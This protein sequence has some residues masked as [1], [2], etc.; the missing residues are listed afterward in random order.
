MNQEM[1]YL[2]SSS[3]NGKD[4]NQNF[5]LSKIWRQIAGLRIISSIRDIFSTTFK[6]IAKDDFIIGKVPTGKNPFAVAVNPMT[7]RI[8]LVIGGVIT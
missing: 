3:L 4:M 8:Y 2:S 1:N 5:R 7:Y 6:D